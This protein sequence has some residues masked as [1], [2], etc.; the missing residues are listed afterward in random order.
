MKNQPFTF[1]IILLILASGALFAGL[2]KISEYV[3]LIWLNVIIYQ[4]AIIIRKL[5]KKEKDS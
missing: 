2:V 5:E 4:L 1:G 3:I